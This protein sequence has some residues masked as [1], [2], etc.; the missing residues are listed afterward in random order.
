VIAAD[1]DRRLQ[2]AARDHLVEGQAQ[3]RAIAQA[4]PTD[5]RGQTLEGDA[6]AGHVE[7]AMQVRVVGQA[8]P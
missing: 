7:P 5:P 3:A 6:F 4:D 2:F 1:H 8:V